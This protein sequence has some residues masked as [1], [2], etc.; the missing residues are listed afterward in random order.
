LKRVRSALPIADET[1]VAKKVSTQNQVETYAV[2]LQSVNADSRRE[3]DIGS[4]HDDLN[5]N[6]ECP[7][8]AVEAAEEAVVLRGGRKEVGNA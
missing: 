5:V 4:W 6:T 8:D 2:A 7:A 3:D 1:A